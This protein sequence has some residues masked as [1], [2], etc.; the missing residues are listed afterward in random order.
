MHEFQVSDHRLLHVPDPEGGAM[1]CGSVANAASVR[2]GMPSMPSF[3]RMSVVSMRVWGEEKPFLAVSMAML[4]RT[5]W[6][7]VMC[8]SAAPSCEMD[9]AGFPNAR[10]QILLLQLACPLGKQQGH[11]PFGHCPAA[12]VC[13]ARCL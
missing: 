8:M 10:A 5:W 3:V 2:G 13:R 1:P 7:V 4:S 9:L 12:C 11:Y 6:L